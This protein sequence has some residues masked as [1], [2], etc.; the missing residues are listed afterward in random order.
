MAAASSSVVLLVLISL[1]FSYGG[2]FDPLTSGS[3]MVDCDSQ[4]LQLAPC[5]PFVQG[6][7]S[8]PLQICCD[9]IDDLYHQQSNCLCLLLNDTAMSAFPINKTLALE[10]PSLC[11]L[12]LN[13]SICPGYVEPPGPRVPDSQVSSGTTSNNSST[14]ASP[15]VALPPKTNMGLMFRSTG[16][17]LTIKGTSMLLVATTLLLI[18]LSN[19]FYS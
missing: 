6:F 18:C 4:L 15:G 8:S 3:S 11:N 12:Q 5:G 2:S 14:A 19:L 7:D 17:K 9:N 13:Y 10:L 1:A 16:E